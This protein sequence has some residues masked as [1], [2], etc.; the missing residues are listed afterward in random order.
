[1]KRAVVKSLV[2]SSFL[3]TEAISAQGKLYANS[4]L[5]IVGGNFR[6]GSNHTNVFLYGGIK[7]Q[8]RKYFL[9][10]SIP[11]V[12][13]G[14]QSFMQLGNTYLSEHGKSNTNNG[15]WLNGGHM[16]A[17]NSDMSS[18]GTGIGD[19][20]INGSYEILA[21]SDKFPSLSIDAYLKVPTATPALGVGSGEFDYLTAV[22]LKKSFDNYLIYAQL[23]YLTVGK[24]KGV[25][26]QNPFTFSFG[27][28]YLFNGGKSSL[29]FAYDSYSTIVR[30]FEAPE[31][32]GV[33]YNYAVNSELFFSALLT[34]G[35]NNST[36]DYSLS[37]GFNYEI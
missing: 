9:S 16:G 25:I 5:Q 18:F 32:V 24:I 36:S 3:L 19:L 37:T 1:M 33:G 20:Y 2:L 26:S 31:Q 27:T 17:G 35:L 8:A 12:F 29:Y 14:N 4:Y 34:V 21:E 15:Q 28:G 6:D 11:L 30:G 7:Y 23:G 10:L 13:T 22:G